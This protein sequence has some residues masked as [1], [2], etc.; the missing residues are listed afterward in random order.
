MIFQIKD[1]I[2]IYLNTTFSPMKSDIYIIQLGFMQHIFL[3]L[4]QNWYM[5]LIHDFDKK[6]LLHDL[7]ILPETIL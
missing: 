2:Y 3:H 1:K 4:K 6:K 7:G 5:Y